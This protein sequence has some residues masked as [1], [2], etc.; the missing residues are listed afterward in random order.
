MNC[1]EV[2]MVILLGILTHSFSTSAV[3]QG[4]YNGSSFNPNDYFIPPSTGWIFSLYYSYS[5]M[6]YFNDDRDKSDKI[7]ISEDPPFSVS[8]G[9]KVKTQSIIPM[10]IYFGKKKILNANWGVL[11]LPMINNPNA[12]IALDFYSGQTAAG[13]T[14]LNIHSFG[15]GD[16]YLQPIW[17]TWSKPKLSFTFS[18]GTWIPIGK[19][20]VNDP[21][22]VG[23]GYWSHNL[24]IAGRYQPVP[25][26]S[27]TSAITLEINSKQ[28][29]ADFKESPHFSFDY[30]G[31]YNFRK[32]HELGFFGFGT[33]QTGRDQGEK[34]VLPGDQIFGAGIYGAYWLL[35]GKLGGLCRLTQ[36]IGTKNRF[37]GTAFQIGINYLLFPPTTSSS[38]QRIRSASNASRLLS[39]YRN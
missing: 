13:S 11:A 22:N 12:N 1:R 20:Q 34:A 3:G 31:S 26:F 5:Q 25:K 2:Y 33:W 9:Q 36:N 15:F 23:L 21:E 32:G 28:R 14:N 17:L 29:G 24:R 19:Y 38:H 10:V 27:F 8:I 35:P 30:G 6:N 16:F 18:Y 39:A 37:G 7:E 4:H